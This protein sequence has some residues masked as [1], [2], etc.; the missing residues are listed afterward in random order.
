MTPPA[1]ALEVRVLTKAFGGLRAVDQV[2]LQVP[3]GERRVLIGPNGAGKT[4]LFNLIAG[5]YRPDHGEIV[6]DGR[7]LTGQP[8]HRMPRLGLVRTFQNIQP[9][10]NMTVLDNV[11]VARHARSGSG[12][13]AAALR[14]PRARGRGRCCSRGR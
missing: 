10:A 3:A 12:F 9:F 1:L 6:F 14:L 11:A 13:L 5:V 2:S 4:T 8:A 7:P